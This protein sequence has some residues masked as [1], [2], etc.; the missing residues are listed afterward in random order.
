MDLK[1]AKNL[2]VLFIG[3]GLKNLEDFL[4]ENIEVHVE[5]WENFDLESAVSILLH[6]NKRLYNVFK[7]CLY[8]Y[9]KIN[10][11][12]KVTKCENTSP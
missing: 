1:T 4:N 6:H 2:N 7:V 5:N 8:Q 10:S 11:F 3:V 9:S 12:V